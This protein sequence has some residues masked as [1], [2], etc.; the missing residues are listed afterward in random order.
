MQQVCG[1]VAGVGAG[2]CFACGER[3]VVFGV[4][5]L[6]ESVAG[7]LIAAD[8]PPVILAVVGLFLSVY[9]FLPPFWFLCFMFFVIAVTR[10]SSR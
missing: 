4:A 9:L 8:T 10:G 1:R 3:S 5:C 7:V 2:G 6:I